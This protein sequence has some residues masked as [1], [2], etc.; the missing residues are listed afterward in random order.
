M[1]LVLADV[2]AEAAIALD[3]LLLQCQL[4]FG[5][6]ARRKAFFGL[7]AKRPSSQRA[8]SINYLFII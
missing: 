8:I 4:H 7:P 3:Q 2:E 1:R 5:S 6:T